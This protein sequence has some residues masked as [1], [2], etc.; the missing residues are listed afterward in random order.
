MDSV[1]EKQAFLSM[2]GIDKTEEN[3]EA[4]DILNREL[5][6]FVKNQIPFF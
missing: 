2:S 1:S 4:I 6:D 5:S 3:S